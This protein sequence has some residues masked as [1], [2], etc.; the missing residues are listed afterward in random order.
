VGASFNQIYIHKKVQELANGTASARDLN[1]DLSRFSSPTPIVDRLGGEKFKDRDDGAASCQL[2]NHFV[3]NNA[4]IQKAIKGGDPTDIAGIGM[5]LG[6]ILTSIN[7]NLGNAMMQDA[8]ALSA[9]ILTGNPTK[10]D[11][12]A[13]LADFSQ[14]SNFVD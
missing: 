4:Q 14:V 11:V 8:Q 9:A 6:V 3:Y 1:R 13:L 10:G 7:S 12:S 5:G 2:L